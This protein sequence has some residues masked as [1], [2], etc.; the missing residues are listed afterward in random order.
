MIAESRYFDGGVWANCPAMA[1]IIEGVCY[2]GVPLD[3]IDILSVGT[4]EEPV[5]F[6]QKIHAGLLGWNKGLIDLLMNAQAESSLRHAQLLTG[7]PRFLRINTMTKPGTY[8]LDSPREIED[9]ASLGN[10]EA[11]R[12]DILAQIG[13]RFLNGVQVSPWTSAAGRTT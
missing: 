4:T 7:E 13:S 3:R 5:S 11:S 8:S 1:A 12:P 9:L 6:K 10:L 2:L